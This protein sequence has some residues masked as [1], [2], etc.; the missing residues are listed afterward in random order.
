MRTEREKM[1]TGELY[2]ANDPEL[3]A[4]RRRA[5]LLLHAF[6]QSRADEGELRAR[7]L[8]E[9]LPRAAGLPEVEPPFFCDYGDNIVLG[10]KVFFNFNCVVLDICRVTIGNRV[11][12]GPAV[13]IYAATHPLDVAKRR[14]GL[15]CGRPVTIGDDVWIGGGAIIL[16]GVTI[17]SGAVI[18]AGSVVS[19]NIPAGSVAY[20]NPAVPRDT[21]A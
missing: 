14:Q 6:N 20:G 3:S 11:L 18:G 4:A 1:L 17:G 2:D 19:R 7:T 13:Q 16:P 15:E 21:G 9:L 8:R 10:E 5:R 12:C